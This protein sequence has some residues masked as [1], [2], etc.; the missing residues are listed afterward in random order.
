MALDVM[1]AVVM[2]RSWLG[3]SLG[4]IDICSDITI[5]ANVERTECEPIGISVGVTLDLWRDFRQVAQ[6]AIDAGFYAE[7]TCGFWSPAEP[8][9]YGLDK[10]DISSE[11]IYPLHSFDI[12]RSSQRLPPG[13]QQNR[14]SQ[15]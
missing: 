12:M 14:A 1:A 5:A 6:A 13:N 11:C 3:V 7:T 2:R 15:P 8:S 9:T 10:L 4:R